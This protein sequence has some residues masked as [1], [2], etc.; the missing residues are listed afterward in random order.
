LHVEQIAP[1]KKE[2]TLFNLIWAAIFLAIGTIPIMSGR[3]IRVWALIV[4]VVFFIV[5][6][7]LP[8]ITAA[9]YKAWVKFGGVLGH[10]NSRIILSLIYFVVITPVGLFIRLLGKDLLNKRLNKD[11]ASYFEDRTIPPGS[12]KN[13][14]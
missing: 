7:T 9:F 2:L 10:I 4:S 12:M 14:Y 8:G 5:A 3:N 1:A 6:F 11:A 13:Q